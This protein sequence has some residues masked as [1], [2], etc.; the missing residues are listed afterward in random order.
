MINNGMQE[1]LSSLDAKTNEGAK[2]LATFISTFDSS[3]DPSK[4]TSA[5]SSILTAI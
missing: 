3:I 4:I 1:I 5:Y 2:D